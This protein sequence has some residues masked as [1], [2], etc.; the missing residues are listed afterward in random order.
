M[1]ATISYEPLV[2]IDIGPLSISPHGIF[3]A[4]GV[5]IGAVFFLRQVRAAGF[6]ADAVSDVLTRSVV[7]ALFGARLAYVLNHLSRYDSPLEVLRVWEGGA[8]LLGGVTAALVVAVFE[9]RRRDLPVLPLLDL[10]APWFTLGVAIGRI[11]DLIIADHLGDPTTSPLGFRCPA[12]VD[13]GGNVGSPCPPGEIVHLTALYDL[14][15][16]AAI[17]LVVLAIRRRFARTGT[18]IASVAILYGIDRLVL[19]D[20]R[21][22]AV[23][24]GLTGSQWTGMFLIAA[25]LAVLY[26]GRARARLS[27]TTETTDD[28]H[29]PIAVQ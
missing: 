7:A 27:E 4:L 26:F 3:T 9:F 8:S 13:V 20:F 2:S 22:D 23:R 24:F 15:A 16:A 5:F 29:M 11:G 6:D 21:A 28:E 17:T 25:G 19:D 10:S 14:F 1:L 12:V 18:A